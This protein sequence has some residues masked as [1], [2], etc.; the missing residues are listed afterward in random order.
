[1]LSDQ[2]LEDT[3]TCAYRAKAWHADAF[4]WLLITLT[5]GSRSPPSSNASAACSLACARSGWASVSR[6]RRS[7][8]RHTIGS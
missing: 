3:L 4:T 5:T 6:T 8:K 2:Q 1:M 7:T